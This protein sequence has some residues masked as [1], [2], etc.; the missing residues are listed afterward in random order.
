MVTPLALVGG[1]EVRTLPE[2]TLCQRLHFLLTHASPASGDPFT[3]RAALG[4]AQ[5]TLYTLSLTHNMTTS[6]PDPSQRP[7]PAA[8][9]SSPPFGPHIPQTPQSVRNRALHP[10]NLLLLQHSL[11]SKGTTTYQVMHTPPSITFF[12]A[13]PQSTHPPLTATTL[14][15]APS[16]P[17]LLLHFSTLILVL[18]PQSFGHSPV[19]LIYHVPPA[20]GPLHTLIPCVQ[21]L[22][23]A[24]PLSLLSTCS[25][26]HLRLIHCLS[27]H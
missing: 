7:G 21:H 20:P 18:C 13:P 9:W 24:L 2:P 27:L 1:G 4:P 25:Y 23:L 16:P 10:T 22:C 6:C 17:S 14:G 19:P 8:Y 15:P 5:P 12:Y 11:L 3:V 26:C